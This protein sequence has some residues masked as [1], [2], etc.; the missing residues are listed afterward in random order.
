LRDKTLVNVL[1]QLFRDEFGYQKKM[2]FAELMIDR[3][4][5]TVEAFVKP[6]SMIEPG[7]MLWMAVPNGDNNYARRPMGKTPQVPVVLTLVSDDDLKALANGEDY[8]DVRRQRLTRLLRE[9]HA[10]G[11][12]L[13]QTD[14][15]ALTLGSEG[16][17]G[18]DIA[19]VQ[20][21]EDCLLPTRGA[22]HDLGPTTTHKVAV[23]RLY[24]AGYLEPDIAK[25]LSPVHSLRSVER[26]VQTYK[27]VK[28]LCQGGFS[29]KDIA[30]ILDIG[31]SLVAAYVELVTDHHPAVVADN[32]C[33]QHQVAQS[34]SPAT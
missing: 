21:E 15:S 2:I 17:V 32:P 4:L 30:S 10:Q 19:A 23:I 8:V 28:K 18:R 11:G 6:A 29:L 26:Y 14:V 33:L 13:A 31:K 5:D 7:Q 25:K 22:L 24:E 3:I 1:R 9:T 34:A 27:N 20:E 12:A 16:L